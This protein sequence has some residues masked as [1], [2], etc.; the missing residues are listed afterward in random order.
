MEAITL[1]GTAPEADRRVDIV[2]GKIHRSYGRRNVDFDVVVRFR[3]RSETRQEPQIGR[4]RHDTDLQRSFG[5]KRI[6]SRVL[7]LIESGRN[8]VEVVLAEGSQLNFARE[9]LEQRLA[10]V[11][12]EILDMA[13]DRTLRH[14]ELGCRLEKARVTAR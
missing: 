14:V 11:V 10:E 6:D 9:T 8:G 3:K 2:R 1:P 13:A 12:L 7:D 5:R 4:G